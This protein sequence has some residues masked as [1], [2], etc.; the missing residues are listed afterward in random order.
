MR[1]CE[2][3]QFVYMREFSTCE[4]A[5]VCRMESLVKMKARRSQTTCWLELQDLSDKIC[6]IAG[7]TVCLFLES[8]ECLFVI[9]APA[10]DLRIHLGP[11]E[12]VPGH[13][14]VGHMGMGHMG[15]GHL[16][17]GTHG[18][19]DIW[20]H[21]HMDTETQGYWDIWVQ[22]HMG[23]GHMGIGT[24][25][26]RDLWVQG[27][28]GTICIATYGYMDLWVQGHMGTMYIGTYGYMD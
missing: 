11:L 28:M 7:I 6:K 21:G 16:G 4:N 20:V 19:W 5:E 27:H 14:G 2:W 15:V 3:T 17:T 12:M 23:T 10:F 22:G 26:Y 24:Y 8:N 13:M 9:F 1:A 25:G 18:Y